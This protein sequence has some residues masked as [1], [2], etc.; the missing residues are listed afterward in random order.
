MNKVKLCIYLHEPNTTW[1]DSV[2]AKEW[3]DFIIV[4]VDTELM[5]DSRG[6]LAELL[7]EY[8]KRTN[9]QVIV[10][11]RGANIDFYGVKLDDES[12]ENTSESTDQ[13]S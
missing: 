6:Q 2:P 9:K 1:I 11:P 7:S 4:S 3:D 5:N 8:G 13:N 10:L 12:P